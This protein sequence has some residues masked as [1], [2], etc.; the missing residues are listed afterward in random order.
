MDE[1]KK[2]LKELEAKLEATEQRYA[3]VL[4]RYDQVKAETE[5]ARIEH[6]GFIAYESR[7]KKLLA[8]KDRELRQRQDE[9]GTLDRRA[10][11]SLL[12]EL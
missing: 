9:L 8:A 1:L 10:T 5:K 2:Q 3:K 6:D 12:N 11:R 4:L 7:A